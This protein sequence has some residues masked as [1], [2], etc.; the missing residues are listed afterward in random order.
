VDDRAKGFMLL[1]TGPSGAG[2]SSLLQWL[3]EQDDRLDFS[4]SCT[5]RPP[6]QGEVDGR[7]YHFVSRAEFER[8]RDAD[9]FV[10]WAEVHGNYYGTLSSELVRAESEGRIPVLEVD[11][12]G[13]VNVIKRF[14]DRVLSVFVFPPSMAVLEGRLRGR[15]TDDEETIARRLANAREELRERNWY[16][17]WLVND[18]RKRARQD[19]LAIFRAE[20]LRRERWTA[21][22]LSD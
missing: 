9:E 10:E 2:K 13:G 6:R 21:P 7:D 1:V 11:V 14:G 16:R 3:M 18:E 5:T 19:L 22:P 12:Q 17:Y 4:V 8:R 15:G 20:E